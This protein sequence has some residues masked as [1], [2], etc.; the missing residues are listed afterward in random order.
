MKQTE[1]P[2]NWVNREIIPAKR[3]ITKDISSGSQADMNRIRNNI[4]PMPRPIFGT[5][6][7]PNAQEGGMG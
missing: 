6:V 4:R 1:S 2:K 3:D 7:H 5:A